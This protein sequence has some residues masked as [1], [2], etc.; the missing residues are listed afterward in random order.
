MGQLSRLDTNPSLGKPQ[1]SSRVAIDDL[2]TRLTLVTADD[3]DRRMSKPGRRAYRVN[4]TFSLVAL[5]TGRLFLCFHH[6]QLFCSFVSNSQLGPIGVL[7]A[8]TAGWLF[9]LV[10]TQ[11]LI[12]A[13][14]GWFVWVSAWA[15]LRAW[16]LS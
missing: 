4:L 9:G 12:V 7:G 1:K 11:A 8:T 14:L 13:A 3:R 6:H 2:G 16:L 15:W 10:L 5:F